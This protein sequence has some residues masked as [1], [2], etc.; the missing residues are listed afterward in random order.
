MY[1]ILHM[2][3]YIYILIY[4]LAPPLRRYKVKG[5]LPVDCM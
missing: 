5:G 3:V 4:L 2:Y 1:V